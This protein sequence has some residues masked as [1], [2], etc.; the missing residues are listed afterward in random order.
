VL[1]L[2]RIAL[3][4]LS[5]TFPPGQTNLVILGNP[6]D[7]SSTTLGWFAAYSKNS[8]GGGGALASPAR[9][10]TQGGAR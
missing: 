7:A 3:K 6:D 10:L 1:L 4:L 8:S 9:A 5:L 2:S